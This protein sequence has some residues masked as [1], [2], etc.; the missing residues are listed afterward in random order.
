MIDSQPAKETAS[1]APM[2]AKK[3]F[4]DLVNRTAAEVDARMNGEVAP[5][6]ADYPCID[7]S[8]WMND[9]G[10]DSP[11]S[12]EAR[13]RVVSQVTKQAIETGSFNII[14]HGIDLEFF[15]H[16]EA[17]SRKFSEM[18]VE[19]KEKLCIKGSHHGYNPLQSESVSTVLGR[20]GCKETE[21]QDLREMY[22]A[23]YPLEGN[24]CDGPHFYR[25]IVDEYMCHMDRVDQ[26]LLKILSVGLAETKGIALP[27]TFLI[28]AKGASKGLLRCSHYVKMTQEYDDAKRLAPHSDWGPLTILYTEAMGLVENRYEEWVQVPARK[29][30]LHVF[31][32]ET[33]AAWTN[34]L[35]KNNVH[36]VGPQT[37]DR[38]S[39]AYFCGQGFDRGSDTDNDGIEPV[40]APGETPKFGKISSGS[41]VLEYSKAYL[42]A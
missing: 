23:I 34:L 15:D 10:D 8:A 4:M 27:E 22:S 41:H 40:C 42:K 39:Y 1:S 25:E 28:Q 31:I 5:V 7:I 36:Y 32:G 30:Q 35:F 16:L 18:P 17:Q 9:D 12:K 38:L 3:Y 29:G 6:P 33:L 20:E 11:I 2:C 13:A 26:V 37:S 14:G 24:M 19:E 21:K